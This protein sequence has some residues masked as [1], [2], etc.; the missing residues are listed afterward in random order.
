MSVFNSSVID[1]NNKHNN[2]IILSRF[3]NTRQQDIGSISSTFYIHPIFN[4]FISINSKSTNCLPDEILFHIF[5]YIKKS[6]TLININTKIK[7]YISSQLK[8]NTD[9]WD[10]TS[11]NINT[12]NYSFSKKNSKD[13]ELALLSSTTTQG[14][15]Y[16][17]IE[18]AFEINGGSGSP[19]NNND[20]N[21]S[22]TSSTYAGACCPY[23]PQVLKSALAILLGLGTIATS[24]L[25][26]IFKPVDH[27]IE[28]FVVIYVMAAFGILNSLMMI[29]YEKSFIFSLP[30]KFNVGYVCVLL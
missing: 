10:I 15:S 25:C 30:S 20:D 26:Y 28:D 6:N 5:K 23:I 11:I 29:W 12:N 24:I 1:F 14:T 22:T 18:T 19:Y 4:W 21:N 16:D 27:P 2:Q 9:K 8:F 7:L 17:N 3:D 13:P